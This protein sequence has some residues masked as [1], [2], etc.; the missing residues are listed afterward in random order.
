M[1]RPIIAATDIIHVDAVADIQRF[2]EFE[3][4]PVASRMCLET[5]KHIDVLIV[6][7]PLPAELPADAPRL[8]AVIRHG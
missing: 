4:T 3:V 6:R 2:A 1:S 5:L 7:N 8:K